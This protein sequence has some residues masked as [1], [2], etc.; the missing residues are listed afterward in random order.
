[1]VGIHAVGEV[2][3]GVLL[4]GEAGKLRM[5]GVGIGIPTVGK[6]GIPTAIGVSW[7]HSQR[8]VG[9]TQDGPCGGVDSHRGPYHGVE[10]GI[11]TMAG[12]G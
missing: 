2:G 1:M 9:G 6:V 4:V 12:V 10:L 8:A 7:R 11:T 5:G 3:W